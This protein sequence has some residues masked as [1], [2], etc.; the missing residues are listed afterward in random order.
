MTQ[1]RITVVG[2]DDPLGEAVVR[3]ALVRGLQVTATAQQPDR[4]P[5]LSPD[6]QLVAARPDAQAEIAAAVRGSDAAVLALSPLPGAEPTMRLTDATIATVRALRAESVPRLVAASSTELSTASRAGTSISVADAD[7]E[8][9]GAFL[10]IAH[11]STGQLR[12]ALAPIRRRRHHGGLQD[13]RRLELLLAGSGLDWTVLRVGALTD[14]L[15]TKR[16]QVVPA[17]DGGSPSI[18]REDLAHALLDQAV[19]PGQEP[20]LCAIRAR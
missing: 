19:R 5:R 10:R 8:P 1:S 11:R 4:L 20:R 7:A 14:L 12:A 9:A 17:A 16:L 18:A 13:L 15:G 2:A 3:E 6:L